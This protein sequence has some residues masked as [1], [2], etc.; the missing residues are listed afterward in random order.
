MNCTPKPASRITPSI[1]ENLMKICSVIFDFIA[2]KQKWQGKLFL[3]YTRT[4]MQGI[5]IHHTTL[6]AL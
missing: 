6:P 1:S 5:S 3:Q 4:V 2:F